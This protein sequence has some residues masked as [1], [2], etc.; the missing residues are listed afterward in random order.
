MLVSIVHPTGRQV[1]QSHTTLVLIQANL[2]L[3]FLRWAHKKLEIPDE[4]LDFGW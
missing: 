4:S 1:S 2:D 3:R